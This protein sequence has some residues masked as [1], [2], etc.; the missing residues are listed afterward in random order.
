MNRYQAHQLVTRNPK[1]ITRHEWLEA[2]PGGVVA[3]LILF[4]ALVALGM[5]PT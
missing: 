2:T 5:L 4:G 1:V 3:A